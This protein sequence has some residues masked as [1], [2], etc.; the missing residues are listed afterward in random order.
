MV[1]AGRALAPPPVV[2]I[3]ERTVV[4]ER[5]AS[6]FSVTISCG[7]DQGRDC[8]GNG[9]RHRADPPRRPARPSPPA[10]GSGG[11]SSAARSSAS[12]PGK[13]K[14]VKAK[15]SRRGVAQAL[16]NTKTTTT[17]K[18]KVKRVK[19]R[20]TIFMRSARRLDHDGPAPVHGR[21]PGA[22]L[23]AGGRLTGQR[24]CAAAVVLGAYA[25]HAL[26]QAGGP[27]YE[28][29]TW[30]Y[31]GLVAFA[32][33]ACTA[34]CVRE[35]RE[36]A[37]WAW[38]AAA[39]CAWLGGE[40]H[41]TLFLADDAITP[42]PSLS[43][44]FFVAFYPACFTAVVLL[45]RR[46]VRPIGPALLLDGVIS[47][48][49]VCSVVAAFT[50]GAAAAGLLDAGA[51]AVAFN[52]AYPLGDLALLGSVAAVL[53]LTGWRPGRALG[54]LAAGLFVVGARRHRV[55]A[56]ERRRGRYVEGGWVDVLWPAG[57]LLTAGA[58]WQ[59]VRPVPLLLTGRRVLTLPILFSLTAL[60]VIAAQQVAEVNRVALGLATATILAV[61]VRMAWGLRS[62][63]QLL[64]ATREE[65]TSDALT[66][67][68]NRRRLMLDA[69]AR[70]LERPERA[71]HLLLL[72]DLDGFK[73]YNDTF[74][75]PEGDALLSRR[76]RAL[77]SAV[78]SPRRRPS[79]SAATSSASCW[80]PARP[81]RRR[82]SRPAAPR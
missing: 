19:A 38:L 27:A 61:V 81:A 22:R 42:F 56:A 17:A 52:L 69:R 8:R 12:S 65:A 79:A 71:H 10:A 2:T 75:H 76:A 3:V 62:N 34:R 60:A 82:W 14:V 80:R 25:L 72:F 23:G 67:L 39:L 21:D 47:A 1:E 68:G 18:G 30:V 4:V 20:M 7:A 66:G 33:V 78:E 63:L 45:V 43:D 26:T 49:A 37:A 5:D 11:S 29:T 44:V 58:A 46:R 70:S 57:L 51:A 73:L 36:R 40:L 15:V 59:P 41:H 24:G 35:Q 77:A 32:A 6:D 53:S 31:I 28:L 13:T 9:A 16:K 54:M 48:L 50:F 55:P 64:A 74:G